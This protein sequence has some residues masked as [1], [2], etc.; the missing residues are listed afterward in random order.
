MKLEIGNEDFNSR[1]EPCQF[2]KMDRFV[3]IDNGQK[4]VTIFTKRC[5]LD[6]WQGFENASEPY[7]IK[8]LL[9]KETDLPVF[10][11]D[12]IDVF[13]DDMTNFINYCLESWIF[14]GDLNTPDN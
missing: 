1:V 6:A 13:F 12:S 2:S 5:I 4:P 3:K 10:L 11:K 7:Y 14:H 9:W 8:N